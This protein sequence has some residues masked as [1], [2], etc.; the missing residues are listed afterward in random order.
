VLRGRRRFALAAV[1]GGVTALLAVAGVL[2]VALDDEPAV[3]GEFVL[4]QPGIYQEPVAGIEVEGDALPAVVLADADGVARPLAAFAG[5][6]LVVNMWYSACAPCAKELADFAEV[7]AELAGQV[8]FVGINPQ[9]DAATM[10][11][12]AAAR[13]VDYPLL[14]DRELRFVTAVPITSYPTT[15]FVSAE[16]EIVRQTNAIDADELRATIAEVF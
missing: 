3:D 4:D 2:A 1:V 9:D 10:L 8:Q 15:L 11:E 6:P 12:F 16:G 5:Q 13:G 14:L 7:S